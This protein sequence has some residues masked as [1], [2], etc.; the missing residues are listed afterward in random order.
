MVSPYREFWSSQINIEVFYCFNNGQEFSA[1]RTISLLC[2]VECLAVI[3]ND[4]LLCLAL[5]I[6]LDLAENCAVREVAGVGVQDV[7]TF[8]ARV[9]QD[10][11][12]G[13]RSPQYVE[14]RLLCIT[15]DPL[16]VLC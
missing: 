4:S 6:D 11:C 12:F 16:L 5:I 13:E 2:R 8:S 14:S 9:S 1:S 15:P 10:W 3:R 7:F